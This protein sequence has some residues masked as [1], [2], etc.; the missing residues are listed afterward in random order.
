MNRPRGT[1]AATAG[2]VVLATAGS[3]LA[4][5]APAS[6]ADQNA[7]MSWALGGGG[8]L[9]TVTGFA[10][11]RWNPQTRV[12]DL[13][14]TEPRDDVTSWHWRETAAPPAS[15]VYYRGSVRHADGT[16]PGASETAVV[17]R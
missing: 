15:T 17:T 11:R 12:L 6:A 14:G 7:W 13:V 16:E 9:A 10:I 5:A 8:N 4:P 2:A 1:E 3:L